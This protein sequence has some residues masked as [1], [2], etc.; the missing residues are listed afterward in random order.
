MFTVVTVIQ[1][2]TVVETL[3]NSLQWPPWVA[4]NW[5]LQRNGCCRD[6]VIRVISNNRHNVSMK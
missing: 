4:S 5:P 6:V 3:A 1:H 2:Y